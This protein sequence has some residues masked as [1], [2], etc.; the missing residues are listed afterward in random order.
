M[1]NFF[2]YALGKVVG[3]KNERELKRLSARVADISDLEPEMQKLPDS[4]FPFAP[5]NL[6]NALLAGPRSTTSFRK[7]L[8][9]A[10]KPGAAPSTCGTLMCSS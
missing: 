10:V 6:R 2:Q 7:P 8:R 1:G 3:T 5:N 9:F 4:E